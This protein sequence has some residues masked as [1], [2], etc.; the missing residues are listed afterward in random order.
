MEPTR[1]TAPDG[2][3]Y[4]DLNRNGV[5]DPYEDARVPV[6]ERVRDL[7]ARLSLPEKAGLLFH[8]VIEAGPDGTL[9]EGP[10]HIA[11]SATREV[12][13]GRHLNHFNVHHLADARSAATWHNR[14]QLL[15]EEGVGR[16]V[17]RR[18]V[19]GPVDQPE[20]PAVELRQGSDV[21]RVEHGVQHGRVLTHDLI[22][23][24]ADRA[25][26]AAAPTGRITSGGLSGLIDRRRPCD[27]PRRGTSTRR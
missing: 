15:A 22:V 14:L 13:C 20:Q 1:R 26:T 12:V 7:L 19:A 21:H 27:R 2:T 16:R 9:L 23:R 24:R 11:K 3:P 4:R 6:G 17:R 18:L 8:T 10:G 5:L 25:C